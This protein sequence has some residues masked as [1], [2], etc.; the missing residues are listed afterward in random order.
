M[1]NPIDSWDVAILAG[2][3]PNPII[4]CWVLWSR[5]SVYMVILVMFR[6]LMEAYIGIRDM[7]MHTDTLPVLD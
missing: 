3:K 6:L 7:K 2:V 5:S 1:P 4:Y